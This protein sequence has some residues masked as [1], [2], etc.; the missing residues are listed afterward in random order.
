[1]MRL[2]MT[3]KNGIKKPKKMWKD[4][5][6]AVI[7]VLFGGSIGAIASGTIMFGFLEAK[8]WHT[9]FTTKFTLGLIVIGLVALGVGYILNMTQEEREQAWKR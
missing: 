5:K 1:M 4:I 3:M 7:T 8:G 9:L 2:N 6:R